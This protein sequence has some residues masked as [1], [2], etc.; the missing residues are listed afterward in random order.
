MNINTRNLELIYHLISPYTLISKSSMLFDRKHILDYYELDWFY[1][2]TILPISE[3]I[4]MTESKGTQFAAYKKEVLPDLIVNNI[5][6]MIKEGE[7]KPGEKLPSER[8][9]ATQM[10]VGRP[11]VRS[12]LRALASMNVIE[13][14][15]GSGT[16]IS[17]LS[18]E[19]LI[20]H[21]EFVYFLDPKSISQLYEARKALELATVALAAER[22]TN[23]DLEE[24]E[25]SVIRMKNADGEGK[26]DDAYELDLAF[27][28]L[29]TTASQNPLLG[30]F[31]D[32]VSELVGI[33]YRPKILSMR[34]T[35]TTPGE[36]HQ[37]ILDALKRRDPDAARSAM[38]IH[39]T[40]SEEGFQNLAANKKVD[41]SD[42]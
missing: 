28:R 34:G 1:Q 20:E 22:I 7:L 33:G 38:L 19:S 18:A 30:Q 5:L 13:I 17:S 14:R 32:V 41:M 3:Q 2:F 31:V 23:D 37:L 40:H 15:P 16:Y 6:R 29:I 26:T 27:H 12:A 8:E 10:N 24:L 25:N 39:L 36:D 42:E 35:A 11:T 4:C 9:L 21:L